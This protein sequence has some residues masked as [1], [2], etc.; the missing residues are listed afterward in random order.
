[1]VVG[2]FLLVTK[3][4]N[5]DDFEDIFPSGTVVVMK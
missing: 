2:L 1:M 4:N 5:V 3:D